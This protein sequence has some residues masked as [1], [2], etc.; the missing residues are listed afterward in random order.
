MAGV[1]KGWLR[2]SPGVAATLHQ[3]HHHRRS[4]LLCPQRH[5]HGYVAKILSNTIHGVVK[6][7]TVIQIVI[8]HFLA[9][10]PTA[11]LILWETAVA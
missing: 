9:T 8:L 6:Y 3:R 2:L 5:R 11:L 7:I 4:P 1:E 10:Q